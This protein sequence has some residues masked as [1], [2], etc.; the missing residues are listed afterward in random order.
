MSIDDFLNKTFDSKNYHCGHFAAELYK[1]LTGIDKSNL[2]DSPS[3]ENSKGLI[4]LIAFQSPCLVFM[5]DL[6][7]TFHVGVGITNDSVCH[8]RQEGVYVD[9]LQYIKTIYQLSFY[10]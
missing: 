4:K 1:H 5:R 10:K 2:A 7:K 9:S 8:L 3:L 6:N